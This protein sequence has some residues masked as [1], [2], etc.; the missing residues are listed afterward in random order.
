MIRIIF[1]VLVSMLIGGFVPV[2]AHA[3]DA[4]RTMIVMDG[5][6]SMWGRIGKQ[7]KLRIAT[8]A[9]NQLMKRL[10]A[11]MEV[12]LMAYG[13]RSQGDC[14]DI[15]VLVK[16]QENSDAK[17][18]KALAAMKFQGKTPL[19]A[20]LRE[21]A[22]ALGYEDGPVTVVMV[23]D[24]LESCQMDP[25]KVAADLEADGF[26]FTAH[27]IGFGLKAKEG[28]RLACI[29]KRTG[30]RYF[31]A[32]NAKAL[33]QALVAAVMEEDLPSDFDQPNALDQIDPDAQVP[34]ADAEEPMGVPEPDVIV[35]E[36]IAEPET[37]DVEVATVAPEPGATSS[38]QK[39]KT[40]TPE[41][42][43]VV[44]EPE[45]E[46]DPSA[47]EVA[48]ATQPVT[49]VPTGSPE[50]LAVLWS[51][52]PLD[53][54]E[55]DVVTM[56]SALSGQW[57]VDLAPGEW[58]VE[59]L[60]DGYI[61]E[62]YVTVSETA[63]SFEIAGFASGANEMATDDEAEMTDE[64]VVD[65]LAEEGV[66]TEE[67]A[68]EPAVDEPVMEMAEVMLIDPAETL[69]L[70][71]AGTTTDAGYRCDAT[72]PCGMQDAATGL[73]F[74]LPPGWA[75]DVP[76]VGSATQLVMMTLFGPEAADGSVPTLLLNP[77]LWAEENGPCTGTAAGALCV[78]GA[79][80]QD[81]LAAVAVIAPSVAIAAAP[82]PD[83]SDDPAA[84][85][86]SEPAAE[87]TSDEATVDA[88]PVPSGADGLV[89]TDGAW[90]AT[91]ATPVISQ[92][93]ARIEAGLDAVVAALATPRDI[94]WSGAFDPA[95][96]GADAAM[97]GSS[98]T[99]VSAT[100]WRGEGV[101]TPI[102]GQPP[103][104]LGVLTG[105]LTLTNPDT[106]TGQLQLGA[107]ADGVGMVNL[108]NVGLQQC[109]ITADVTIT[110]RAE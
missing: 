58:A 86:A 67:P 96:F 39:K 106:I 11:E 69:A 60:A 74:A 63:T 101:P 98:W 24:G 80:D 8:R 48:M 82:M 108:V 72:D 10:P 100:A 35:E 20:S 79:G 25:C 83:L 43:V 71:G 81:T 110:R 62:D 92:C 104:V 14:G 34:L 49:I 3:Q 41:A 45:A 29:A 99:V 68:D 30:G 75:T 13:H 6:G 46:V 76:V 95:A 61:F 38:K 73:V 16:P 53:D 22:E 84:E 87:T 109:R 28:A 42:E 70:P 56:E 66:A 27:V 7:P 93:P 40:A 9:V 94:T 107:F 18:R 23:T 1:A 12:G 4:A 17:I 51:A 31:P 33:A 78:W 5:S 37:P 77:E 105:D 103:F 91:V 2:V 36:P 59:G 65:A 90:A 26:D 47:P 50:G 32:R 64:A 102:P 21:A 85:P 44:V 89:P 88:A 54:P 15:Q 52:T 97:P 57:Q 19:A 55:A